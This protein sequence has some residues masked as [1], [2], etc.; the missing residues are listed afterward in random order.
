[1]GFFS[2]RK[3]TL[4]SSGVFRGFIDYHSH[5]L[6]GVDDG[7]RTMEDSIAVLKYYESLGV[8]EV[9][10][11]PHIMEDI[12]NTTQRLRKTFEE[13]C[14]AYDG[15]I[16][17]HLAAEN[18]MDPLFLERLEAGDV[19]PLTKEGTH[20]LVET[21]YFSPPSNMDDILRKVM[22]AEYFPVLAHPERYVYMETEDYERLH[23]MGVKFQ[24][25]LMSLAGAYGSREQQKAQYL[26]KQNMYSF[27]GTDIH[28]LKS[29]E[30]RINNKIKVKL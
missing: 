19:L 29:F 23:K 3:D 17:L 16:E 28:S 27:Y 30:Q 10:C 1:M 8:K 5:I 25:N 15:P 9:W 13:L 18:M 24:L 7:I 20:L 11:T 4:L 14:V 22:S 2:F 12:P 21:S 26:L 6:P